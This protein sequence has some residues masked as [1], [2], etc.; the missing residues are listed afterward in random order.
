MFASV[1]TAVP[2]GVQVSGM[3]SLQ[4]DNL[5]LQTQLTH[6]QDSYSLKSLS[7]V[8]RGPRGKWTVEMSYPSRN[9]AFIAIGGLQK[10][11]AEMDLDLAWDK[12]RDDSAKVRITRPSVSETS[13]IMHALVCLRATPL[14]TP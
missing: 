10:N 8:S 12:D 11:S 14:L 9:I 13:L 1:Y 3:A 6:G 2:C 7:K 4:W 5:D